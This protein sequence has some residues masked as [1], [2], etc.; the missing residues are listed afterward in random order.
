MTWLNLLSNVRKFPFL[1]IYVVMFSDVMQTFLKFSIICA[2]FIIA[3]SLGFH[4]L[5]AEQENFASV[6]LSLVKTSVM[7]IGEFEFDDLFFDNVN[8]E[9]N[10]YEAAMP[11]RSTTFLFFLGFLCVMSIIVMNLLVGLAVDDIKAV[12]DQAVLQRLAMQVSDGFFESDLEKSS[13]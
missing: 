13:S 7:M 11:Y 6:P 12:Q 2:L 1:G 3:F 9:H 4:T 8:G 5:L 10:M